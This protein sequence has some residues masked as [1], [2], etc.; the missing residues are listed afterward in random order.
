MKVTVLPVRDPALPESR[1]R[2]SPVRAEPAR[3]SGL[4]GMHVASVELLRAPRR[5]PAPPAPR[6]P[7]P[8]TAP[9]DAK[10]AAGDPSALV[11]ELPNGRVVRVPQGF[12]SADLERVLAIASGGEPPP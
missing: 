2:A 5:R 7:E 9:G 6:A 4:E 10:E 11:I 12:S 8:V 1:P 3:G